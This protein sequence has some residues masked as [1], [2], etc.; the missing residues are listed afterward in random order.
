M[1]STRLLCFVGIHEWAAWR[2]H[3]RYIGST[4]ALERH[5]RRWRDRRRHHLCGAR[6]HWHYLDGTRRPVPALP[7]EEVARG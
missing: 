1:M 5:C 3:T 7:V 4:D 2:H 6:Q